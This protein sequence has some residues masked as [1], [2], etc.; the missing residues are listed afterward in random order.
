QRGEYRRVSVR[1]KRSGA[2]VSTRTGFALSDPTARMDRQQA[3]Q[4][5]MGAPFP[6]QGLP[7]EYTTYTIAGRSAG[8]Q[9]VILSLAV[10][11]PVASAKDSRAV[12]VVSVVGSVVD[13]RVVASGRDSIAL[14]PAAAPRER[15]RYQ[16]QL[17]PA[18]GESLMRAAVRERG[19]LIG[20]A[21]RRFTV[22]A[23]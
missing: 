10:D 4:R 13:G 15:A 14:P 8:V 5:A 21:D 17:D 1:V 23:L 7:L 9:T 12:E 6:L 11:L 19:G 20:T 18:A 22:R 3:I 2:R 16:V